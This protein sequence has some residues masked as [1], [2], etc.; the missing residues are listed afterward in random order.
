M[1]QIRRGRLVG[2]VVSVAA[3]AALV[4]W[5]VS[6]LPF[7]N[8]ATNTTSRATSKPSTVASNALRVA[9]PPVQ[10]RRTARLSSLAA[11]PSVETT[12][13]AVSIMSLAPA[14][15]F[16]GALGGY[17]VP[18]EGPTIESVLSTMSPETRRYTERVMNLT[19]EQLAAGAAGHP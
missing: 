13:R 9:P 10:L 12:T 7:D 4:T 1:V 3:L 2:L 16:A 5:A 17:A 15:L 11:T 19:F 18:N 14:Q 6:S 8:G